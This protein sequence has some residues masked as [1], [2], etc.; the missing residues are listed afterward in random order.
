LII[1]VDIEKRANGKKL[2]QSRCPGYDRLK[3]R[4][5]KFVPLWGI[6]VFFRYA[7]RRV[8]CPIHGIV[9]EYIPWTEGKSLLT[10]V[11]NFSSHTGPK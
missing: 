6:P 7:R 1:I 9:A 4:D 5:Y 10:N 3:S 11:F 8:N 2:C